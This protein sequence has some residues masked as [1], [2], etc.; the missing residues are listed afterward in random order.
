MIEVQF[1]DVGLCGKQDQQT[2]EGFNVVSHKTE[3]KR[4]KEEIANS[5]EFFLGTGELSQMLGVSA[6]TLNDQMRKGKIKG[7]FRIGDRWRLSIYDAL[8][9]WPQLGQIGGP[10]SEYAKRVTMEKIAGVDL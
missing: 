7:A 4:L 6:V 10:L 5:S 1:L 3:R 8:Q 2:I 9:N